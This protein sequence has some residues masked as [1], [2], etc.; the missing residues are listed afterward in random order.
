MAVNKTPSVRKKRVKIQQN[1]ISASCLAFI[2]FSVAW[3][4]HVSDGGILVSSKDNSETKVVVNEKKDVSK[5]ASSESSSSDLSSVNSESSSIAESKADEN[6]E[7]SQKEESTADEENTHDYS[8]PEDT[9]DDLS[10]AVFIGDSRTVGLENTCDKPKATFYCAVGL[11]ISTVMENKV[12]TLDN[13]NQGTVIEALGQKKFGRVFINFGTNELGWPYIENFQEEYKNLIDKIKELQ[14]GAE[15]YAQAIMPVTASKDAE[16]NDVNNANAVRFNE[17][18][19]E[20]A[21]EAGVNYLDCTPA[22]KNE[23]GMLP[24]EASTDGVHLVSEYCNYW[25]NFIIDNT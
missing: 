14:P 19:M 10:D 25:L 24:E 20:V 15:I 21:E 3:G 1:I 18:I 5:E 13:G 11:N 2:V 17:A 4:V 8:E 23:N 16:G 7:S 6:S 9:K 12:I 22:V